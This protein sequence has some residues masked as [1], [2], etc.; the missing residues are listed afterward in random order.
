[1]I[2]RLQPVIMI[3]AV[4]ASLA[5]W[6]LMHFNQDLQGVFHAASLIRL[7]KHHL[8]SLWLATSA[9]LFL[10]LIGASLSLRLSFAL[11][12]LLALLAIGSLL[13]GVRYMV[14]E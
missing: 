7:K 2:I 6:D 1:M 11:T 10:A 14:D 12:L 13:F 8:N 9:G 3:V 5:S 4:S